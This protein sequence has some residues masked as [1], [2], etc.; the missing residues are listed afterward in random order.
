M[1]VSPVFGFIVASGLSLRAK[2]SVKF[3]M[4]LRD[5]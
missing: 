4:V 1:R 3:F 2:P 5:F